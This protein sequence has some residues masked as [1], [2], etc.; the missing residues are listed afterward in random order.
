[1][2]G[3]DPEPTPSDLDEVGPLTRQVLAYE[4]AMRD[5]VPLVKSAADWRP[6]ERFVAAERFVR[7]GTFLEVQ[8]WAQYTEMLTAWANTID[9]FE[10][11]VRRV[12]ELEDRVYYEIEERHVRG[13]DVNIVNS[14]TVFTFDQD[15]MMRRL[16][17]YLQRAR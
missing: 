1:M 3:N 4:Q 17:V 14:M 15:K 6:L 9:S 16:D 10:T 2:A 8:D 13:S 7:V 12:A 5:L 11:T